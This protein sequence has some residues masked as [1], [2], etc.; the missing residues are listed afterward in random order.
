MLTQGISYPY[1]HQALL[2]KDLDPKGRTV[3]FYGS[4]FGNVDSD[5]DRVVRG[6][7]AKTILEN[8]PAGT[9][10]IKHLLQ[11]ET[12]RPIG[13]FTELKE[14]ERGLLA[15]SVI[16]DS[17]DG[18]DAIALYE[19]DLLEHSIGY[20][21]IKQQY[22]QATG[23]NDLTEV[24]LR[25][26]SSVTWGANADTPLVGMKCDTAAAVQLSLERVVSRH[27]K[28]VKA[29]RHGHISDTLGQQLADE[30]E[31]L[32]PAYKHLISLPLTTVKPAIP[33]TPQDAEPTGEKALN[34]LFTL[35]TA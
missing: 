12:R 13:R 26:I 35:L 29:L 17:T 8:G 25:E 27:D 20:R 10:R 5:N 3:Q 33:V 14:D 7:Y 15:T 1:A 32:Q 22:D 2:L 31:A 19:L 11:H 16:A 24:G 18:N 6:A 9:G 34:T 28:L 4:A 30:L 23:V 21:V